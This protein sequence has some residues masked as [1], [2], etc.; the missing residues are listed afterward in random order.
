MFKLI[1]FCCA[2]FFTSVKPSQLEDHCVI[3]YLKQKN[4]LNATTYTNY[5]APNRAKNCTAVVK[6]IVNELYEE[7]YDYV[8]DDASVDNATYR[9]CLQSEFNRNRMNEKFLKDKIF[10]DDEPGKMKLLN[11][12]ENLLGHIK[13]FCTRANIEQASDRFK[14][15]VTDDGGLSRKLTRH[16]AIQKIK[17]NLVCINLYAV[18]EKILDPNLYNLKLKPIN[19]RSDGYC[20]Q[21]LYDVEAL[22]M[23][24]WHIRRYSDDD[25]IQRCY[26]EILL[27]TQA[28]ESFI[29]NSLLSQ[30]QL[31]QEQK[32][33]EH[34]KFIESSRFVHEMLYKCMSIDFEK[35]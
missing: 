20:K 12:I 35:I 33:S 30:L 6:K 18:E 13:I 8:E 21:V 9:S 26:I 22:I 31:T 1:I 16:P 34:E 25:K 2:L 10:D 32:D 29:R 19:N 7:N 23:D 4:L 28:V 17:Q 15:F 14:E 11:V 3:A 5:R 27:Q 24:E